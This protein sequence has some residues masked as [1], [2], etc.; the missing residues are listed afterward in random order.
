MER[1]LR[2]TAKAE[3]AQTNKSLDRPANWI[4]I[5]RA[6]RPLL[7]ATNHNCARFYSL[8]SGRDAMGKVTSQGLH[9]WQQYAMFREGDDPLFESGHSTFLLQGQLFKIARSQ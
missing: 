3:L 7:Q 2:S 1:C 9:Y 4:L 5:G 6:L 8:N